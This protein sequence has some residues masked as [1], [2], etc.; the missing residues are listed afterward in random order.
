MRLSSCK[1][2]RQCFRLEKVLSLQD[3]RSYA[4]GIYMTI[5]Y[6]KIAAAVTAAIFAAVCAGCAKK[7]FSETPGIGQDG[8]DEVIAATAGPLD[9]DDMFSKRDRETSYDDAQAVSISLSDNGILYDSDK[10]KAENGIVTI[11][12][13]GT[14][15]ISGTLSNGGIV[16]SAEKTDKLQIVLNG[17][18]ISRESSAAIYVERADKV[19]VTL[20]EGTENTLSNKNG[21]IND[22]DVNIDAVV[23]S[24]DDITFN[25][26][27][28]LLISASEGHGIV[29]KDD[30]VFCGGSYKIACGSHGLSAKDSIRIASGDYDI[31]SGKD[32]IHAENADD[33]SLGYVYIA[34]GNFKI[35]SDGDGVSAGTVLQIEDGLF[36]ITAGGGNQNGATHTGDSF[37]GGYGGR[38]PQ[39]TQTDTVSTKGLKAGTVLSVSDGTFHID[40]ADDALHS[41]EDVTV[42]GGIFSIKTGDDGIHADNHAVIGGGSIVIE[43]SYEG[44]EGTVVAISGGEIRITASDDGLNA[45]G[46]N[47]G[48]GFGY[49]GRPGGDS[50]NSS[51]QIQISGGVIYINA[52]GDGVDSNGNVYV[53]GGETYVSGPVSNADA[54]LDY[55]GNA[56]ITG[57]I[58]VAAG[59]NGMAQNFGTGSTQGSILIP[60]SGSAGQEI[61]LKDSSGNVLISYTPEKSY[62]SVLISCPAL[63]QGA[64]YQIILGGQSTSVTLDSLIYTAGGMGGPGGGPGGMGGPG[65]KPGGEGK[66][67]R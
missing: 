64:A 53:S 56:Q 13:E 60:A 54:A 18:S 44:I 30:L 45:A 42:I 51:N 20:A 27:G 9:A 36:D 1:S 3:F 52:G 67:P 58:F 19:F 65:G 7:P 24:R 33:T 35:I 37:F 16:I 25:G 32:G 38:P 6:K 40:S 21:Y 41:N 31:E 46:G 57:G 43:T 34:S 61:V 55:D 62:S 2:V 50:A 66:R 22:G 47:D 29:S 39:D 28:S 12:G 63:K 26:T 10:V 23:F 59:A 14:Y 49:G 15:I 4:E 48:S 11:S 8:A 17:V 5:R